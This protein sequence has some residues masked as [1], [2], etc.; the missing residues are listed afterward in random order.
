MSETVLAILLIIS[1]TV[2]GLFCGNVLAYLR[3]KL[4]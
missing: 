2:L 1:T 4:S 3:E